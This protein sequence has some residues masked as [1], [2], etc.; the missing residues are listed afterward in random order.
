MIFLGDVAHPFKDPPNFKDLTNRAGSDHIVLNLEGP[1]T[2]DLTLLKKKILFNHPSI[3]DGFDNVDRVVA[4]LANNHISDIENGIAETKAT[5]SDCGIKTVG[6]GSSLAEASE[7]IFIKEH[8]T[9]IIIIAFGWHVIECRS[10]AKTRA[11]VQPLNIDVVIGRIRELHKL[12][13]LAKIIPV[14]HWNYEMEPHPQ[15]AHR[16]LAHEAI[17]SGA[18]AIIGRHPHCVGDIEIYKG[19]MIAYSIGNWWL[20]QS[21]FFDG[22]LKYAQNSLRQLAIQIDFE[23]QIIILHRYQYHAKIHKLE[24]IDSE[25]ISLQKGKKTFALLKVFQKVNI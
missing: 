12:Y 3:L 4:V 21:V 1:L 18:S 23:N 24:Y 19:A 22:K 9:T 14:F 16:K 25:T 15:P 6:A 5:L 11:G 20:P 13:P 7:P 2:N 10:A 8:D 17:D